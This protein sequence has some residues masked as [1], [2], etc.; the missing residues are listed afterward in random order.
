MK[1]SNRYRIRSLPNLRITFQI[2]NV[3]GSGLRIWGLD[4]RWFVVGGR[5]NLN[6]G[7]QSGAPVRLTAG[8]LAAQWFAIDSRRVAHGEGISSACGGS[9]FLPGQPLGEALTCKTE[10]LHGQEGSCYR[11]D[12]VGSSREQQIVEDSGKDRSAWLA[13]DLRRM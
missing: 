9:R 3:N 12:V 10:R 11:W 5:N 4:R 1:Y 6:R 13:W 8:L 7:T 2:R